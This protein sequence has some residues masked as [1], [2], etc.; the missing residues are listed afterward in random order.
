VSGVFGTPGTLST[1]P[2]TPVSFNV[3]YKVIA[4]FT[5]VTGEEGA[6]KYLEAHSDGG[7]ADKPVLLKMGFTS[8]E[9]TVAGFAAILNELGPEPSKV[10]KFVALDLSGCVYNADTLFGLN[11]TATGKAKIVSLKL[12]NTAT[13]V[14]GAG[15]ATGTASSAYTA[16]ETVSGEGIITIEDY[17][18]CNCT[19]LKEVNFPK[20]TGIG[21]SAFAG[22]KV[23][24]EHLSSEPA[25]TLF[26]PEAISIGTSA[27]QVCEKLEKVSASK[28]TTIGNEA[29]SSCV[30]LE[31]AYFSSVTS[32]GNSAFASSGTGNLTITMGNY[33]PWVGT[34]I[35]SGV[36]SKTVN[37][38]VPPGAVDNYNDDDDTWKNAFRGKGSIG[39]G[40][41]NP[42]II[43]NV[44]D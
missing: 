16:L 7:T 32:I 6:L 39:S 31:T 20:V 40:P 15:P 35:F 21:V 17:A 18:F 27:F 1:T 8:H 33:A 37:I 26:F 25:P 3:S 38:I 9:A 34:S 4:P 29:F 5:T 19:S 36:A 13:S 30:K 42:N 28:V 23:L 24:G 43:V 22:C 11:V 44:D 41:L 12:P 10:D 14:G 2:I